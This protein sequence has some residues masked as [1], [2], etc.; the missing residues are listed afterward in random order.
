MTFAHQIA[1]LFSRWIDCVAAAIIGVRGRFARTHPVHFVEAADGTFSCQTEGSPPGQNET[2][3]ID[4][5]SIVGSLPA[6]VAS[7]IGSSRVEVVLQPSHFMFRPLELPHRAREFLSGIVRAQI[8]RLTPWSATDAVFGWTTPQDIANDRIVV[9]V[10]ATARDLIAPIVTAFGGRGAAAIV[11]STIP[12]TDG[13]DSRPITVFEQRAAGSFDRQ[14]LCRMLMSVLLIAGLLTGA[15]IVADSVIGG[16]LQSQQDDVA[17]S[18][19]ARRAT[20]QAS[21]DSGGDSAFVALEHRKYITPSSIIVIEALSRIFPDQ[22]YVTGL[23][24]IGDKM[25]VVGE[26]L[27]APALIGLIEQSPYFTNAAFFAPT[28]RSPTQRGESFHIEAKIQPNYAP[29]S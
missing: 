11:V 2:I 25:Q 17:R 29:P 14:R 9:T 5:G 24:I 6:N 1:E 8:D 22:T 21:L 15:A 16:S 28:T 23:R 27:D 12:P 19:V 10:A 18:I 3:R 26:T 4:D 20:L 7:A 13:G